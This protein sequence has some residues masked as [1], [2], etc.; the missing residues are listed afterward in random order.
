[1]KS[2]TVTAFLSCSFRTD[3]IEINNLVKA[4]CE[5]LDIS[6]SNV[7]TGFAEIPPEKA[8]E[9]IKEAGVFIGVA[10]KRSKFEGVEEYSMPESVNNEISIAWTVQKPILLLKEK[11]VKVEGFTSNYC[12][13]LEFERDNMTS[14]EMI[15]K[16]VRA[17]HTLKLGVLN[18]RELMLSQEIVE[19]VA[20]HASHLYE[21]EREGNEFIW[22]H[23]IQR[24][25][26]F[27]KHYTKP[28]NI[29]RWNE[30]KDENNK[31]IDS[32]M[33]FNFE[34]INSSKPFIS[35]IETEKLNEYNIDSSVFFEP[36]P[37]KGD[38]I[39]YY[40]S[41]RGR[42]IMVVFYDDIDI[43]SSINLNGISFPAYDGVIP[44]NRAQSL[45]IQFRF[46]REYNLEMK[47]VEFFVGSYV[48]DIE[49]MVPSEIERAN[50]KKELVGG[51]ITITAE[52]TSPLLRHVY[53]V[54]WLPPKSFK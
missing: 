45:T 30:F 47:N 7:S 40:V 34:I 16:L 52:I 20:E 14:G 49:Y 36:F 12:T 46:P 10:V 25:I 50:V 38:F 26:V 6:C 19:F 42:N 23:S 2:A 39:E 48:K 28:I 33:E 41:Y 43:D 1:M 27:T 3:D 22:N 18:D 54:A 4:I 8:K 37:E 24:K 21:L 17:L 29:G 13:Y 15:T 5:G 44:V 53:G 11:N 32:K 31:N 9:L 35:K 51:N